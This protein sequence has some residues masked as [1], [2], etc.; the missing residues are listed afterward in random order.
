[1]SH[2]C[3]FC[4]SN[5]FKTNLKMEFSDQDIKLCSLPSS[6]KPEHIKQSLTSLQA[7]FAK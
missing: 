1:M 5:L 3:N 7:V 6:L 4:D 2:M